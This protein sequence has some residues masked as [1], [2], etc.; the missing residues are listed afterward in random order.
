MPTR[1]RANKG[2]LYGEPRKVITMIVMSVVAILYVLGHALYVFISEFRKNWKLYD[3]LVP[4]RKRLTHQPTRLLKD[5]S[6]VQ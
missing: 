1:Q 6:N 5:Y 4:K 2:I 3:Y